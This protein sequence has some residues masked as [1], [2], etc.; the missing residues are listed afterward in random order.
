MVRPGVVHIAIRGEMEGR[1]RKKNKKEIARRP[2]GGGLILPFFQ[3]FW[4]TRGRGGGFE[5]TASFGCRSTHESSSQSR[6][7]TRVV[8]RSEGGG[9]GVI[10][11]WLYM[12]V[13]GIDGAG[14]NEILTDW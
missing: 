9:D 14:G 1:R 3:G 8:R 4:F 13:A 7:T 12:P 2:S 11:A 6:L 10:W 5:P